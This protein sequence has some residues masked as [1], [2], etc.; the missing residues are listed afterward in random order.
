MVRS[1]DPTGLPV[2]VGFLVD[3]PR[4]FGSGWLFEE[5]AS[6]VA[7]GAHAGPYVS[8]IHDVVFAVAQQPLRRETRYV[9]RLAARYWTESLQ[10][11]LRTVATDAAQ[12][13]LELAPEIRSSYRGMGLI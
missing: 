8:D 4:F 11:Q 3:Q 13:I 10:A 9:A 2:A 1:G 6:A 7:V 12:R 5:V